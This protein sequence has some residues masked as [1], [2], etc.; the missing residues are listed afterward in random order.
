MLEVNKR[1]PPLN[2]IKPV[3]PNGP[4]DVS[5]VTPRERVPSFKLTPP[6]KVF[7]PAKVK[8]PDPCL[9]RSANPAKIFENV[10]SWEL[11]NI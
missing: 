9:V 7:W 8:T 2:V 10:K 1:V 3:F 4:N 6:V 5:S 11:L